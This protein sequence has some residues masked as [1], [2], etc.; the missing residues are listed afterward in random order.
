MIKE[1]SFT[2]GI[3]EEYLLVERESRDLAA[4]PPKAF[5]TDCEEALGSHVTAEFLRCQVEIGT[6]VCH[7]IHEVRHELAR[8]RGTVI[9]K[10]DKHD[11]RV[12][13]ASTHP[14]ANWGNLLPTEKERYQQLSD[15]LQ[16]VIRRLM[17]CGMHVHVAIE[18]D[19]LRIDLF[20]QIRYFLPHLLA[21]TT[22]SPFWQGKEAGLKSY[23]LAAFDEMPRTGM[24]EVFDNYGNYSR[25]VD[26]LVQTGMIED[27]SKIWWDI[28][29]SS[30]FPTLELRICDVCTNFEDAI[31]VAALYRCLL[32]FLYRLRRDNQRWRTYPTILINENRWMAQRHGASGRLLDL[33]K[34]ECADFKDLL[35]ELLE[36]IDEDAEYFQCRAAIEHLRAIPSRGT[37]ADTQLRLHKEALAQGKQGNDAFTEVVDWLADASIP[38]TK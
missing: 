27:S 31:A 16:M 9:E 29:P 1:P 20:N 37:S 2:I 6:P 13:A 26:V 14:F 17:I 25:T 28:R 18:D 23:R 21:L 36:L 35:E 38:P 4:D 19:D 3:E 22:S 10:A 33:G 7:S 30:R 5:M 15:D 32:R 12:L 34:Q 24:P 11:L 8:L